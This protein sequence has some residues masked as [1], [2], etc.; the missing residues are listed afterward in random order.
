MTL[1]LKGIL[2]HLLKIIYEEIKI[3]DNHIENFGGRSQ[4]SNLPRTAGGP[5]WI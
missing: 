5:N 3:E 2:E 1:N 4:E